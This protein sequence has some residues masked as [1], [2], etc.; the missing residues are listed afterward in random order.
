MEN[1]NAL[2]ILQNFHEFCNSKS[3]WS[4]PEIMED[5]LLTY[6]E[7][8]GFWDFVAV[9]LD[10]KTPKQVEVEEEEEDIE[11]EAAKK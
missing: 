5:E 3:D 6:M 4:N 7:K 9:F 10:V 1:E 8:I 2:E 11:R